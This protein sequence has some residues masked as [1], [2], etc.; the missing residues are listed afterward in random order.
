MIAICACGHDSIGHPNEGPC[1]RESCDC[2]AF[3]RQQQAAGGWV[4]VTT[5]VDEAYV[6][7]VAVL[8][9]AT[10]DFA[11]ARW[12]KI[13]AEADR[14]EARTRVL[15]LTWWLLAICVPALVV[16]IVWRVIVWP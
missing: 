14:V 4:D 10:E 1:M 13:M 6:D 9:E 16:T 12:I 7:H 5:L 15:T 8:R 2:Q 3:A 11:K